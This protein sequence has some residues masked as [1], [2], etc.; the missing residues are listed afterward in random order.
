[1]KTIITVLLLNVFCLTG[2]AQDLNG[3]WKG[4]MNGPNG[5]MELIFTFKVDHDSLSGNVLTEMGPLPIENGKVNGNN[6]S[7]DVNANGQE[8]VNKGV[9]ANDTIKLSSNQIDNPIILS[10]VAEASKIDGKWA[11]KFNGR[12]GEV[13]L[14]FTF[15]VE[16]DS[17]V[18]NVSSDM[19]TL[20]LENGK[21]NGNKFS[22]DIDINGR[23][24][25]NTGVLEGDTIKLS[26][27]RRDQPMILSRVKEKSKIDGTWIGKVSGPQGDF[28]LTF[29]FKVI[30]DT[31]TGKSSSDMGEAE[32]TD[33]LVNGDKFSFDVDA[34]GMTIS[35]KCKYL[36]DDT[37]AMKA[38]VNG[39]EMDMKLKRAAK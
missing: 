14:T 9:L 37:I 11:G 19:G 6:F 3:K 4:E 10:R 35:H 32:I 2:L 16:A 28:E 15:K 22:Y 34:G 25:S 31:L 27:P 30:G 17:L 18:G 8:Y 21:I 7:F 39:R 5:D 1:M 38:D 12:Q 24:I 13:D 36:P 33:G 29:T 20:P 26:S 23:I